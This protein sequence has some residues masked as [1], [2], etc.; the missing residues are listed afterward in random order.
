V[1]DDEGGVRGKRELGQSD[2]GANIIG[3]VALIAVGILIIRFRKPLAESILRREEAI[4]KG[5]G[6]RLLRWVQR[7]W[8]LVLAGLFACALGLYSLVMALRSLMT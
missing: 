8:S 1:S 6:M 2:G 3:G 4:L 7:P 5:R